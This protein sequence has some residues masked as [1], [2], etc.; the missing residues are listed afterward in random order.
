MSVEPFPIRRCL[1]HLD[2]V[3]CHVAAQPANRRK[4]YLRQIIE[5]HRKFLT[6]VGVE[7]G[8]IAREIR[9]L[10]MAVS[11]SPSPSGGLKLAA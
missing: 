7:P 1:H 2:M 9:D 5:Q 4:A 11:P 10:E 6:D 8:L 3:R